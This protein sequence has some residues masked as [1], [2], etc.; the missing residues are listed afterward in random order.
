MKSISITIN[1]LGM[2]RNA[3]TVKLNNLMIFS[4][5]SGLGKSYVA[6]L[7]HYFFDVLLDVTRFNSFFNE[8]G[9]NYNVMRPTFRNEGIAL[10]FNKMD[11]E[12]WLAKDAI[13]Y[14]EYMINNPQMDADIEVKLPDVIDTN[15]TISYSE[16]VI[17]LVNKE[18]TYLKL[19]LDKISLRIKDDDFHDES[20]FALLVRYYLIKMLFGDPFNLVENFVFPPS[21][22]PILT[23]DMQPITGMYSEFKKCLNK[24]KRTQ[25]DGD[26]GNVNRSL[27]RDIL[28]GE[29]TYKENNYFY[30]TGETEMPIS[31]AAASI[32][33]LASI[34]QMVKKT[35]L[36]AVSV[37]IEEPEAHLHPM[38][39]RMMADV[40]AAMLKAGAYMQI[41]THSDYYLRRINELL[42]LGKLLR[43]HDYE[44]IV[45]T[46]NL[47]PSIAI[48]ADKITA[49]LLQRRK[50]DDSAEIIEQSLENGIPFSS[51]HNALKESLEILAKLD[52]YF[53]EDD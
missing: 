53:E 20:P 33:E 44:V 47:S 7:C 15:I 14:V 28:N 30:R 26:D 25:R 37:L 43:R 40:T 23:E 3:G 36:S 24:L 52:K 51:F 6:I 38:K 8:S 39:Q 1:K 9:F 42:L 12:K 32:R 11:L 13:R 50:D 49:Y 35:D 21:R 4:G 41:T 16:E 27:F 18:E 45:K 10:T 17:G 29:V 19:T 22:G 34:E 46:L 48:D 31:A 2:L 5:E